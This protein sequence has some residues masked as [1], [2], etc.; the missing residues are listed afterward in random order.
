MSLKKINDKSV[1]GNML[2][3]LAIDYCAILQVSKPDYAQLE[4]CIDKAVSEETERQHEFFFSEFEQ[5]LQTYKPDLP[6]KTLRQRY[7]HQLAKFKSQLRKQLSDYLPFREVCVEVREFEK[8]AEMCC[9]SF[10]DENYSIAYQL[11]AGVLKSLCEAPLTS[12]LS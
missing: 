6:L 11:T 5:Y 12:S 4:H 3:S 7:L 9:Q 10:L 8:R 1:N 2:L